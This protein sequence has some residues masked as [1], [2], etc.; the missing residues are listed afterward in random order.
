MVL[1][2]I[3]SHAGRKEFYTVTERVSALTGKPKS[4]ASLTM[5]PYIYLTSKH[6]QSAPWSRGYSLCLI[7]SAKT[8]ANAF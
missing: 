8:K 6:T 3:M 7:W 2:L 5:S 1:R 4:A